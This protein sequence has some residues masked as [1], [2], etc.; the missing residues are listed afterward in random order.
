MIVRD[1]AHHWTWCGF[2][3]TKG[4]KKR[5]GEERVAV[6]VENASAERKR[7]RESDGGP[8]DGSGDN[9]ERIPR[10]ARTRCIA[11][12]GVAAPCAW[13]PVDGPQAST[14]A[15]GRVFENWTS[16]Q[17]EEDLRE[18]AGCPTHNGRW[19][20]RREG[21]EETSQRRKRDRWLTRQNA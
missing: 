20:F 9:V 4:L 11:T 5:H 18:R 6:L 17:E 19:R 1:R 2:V 13:C 14:F 10:E 8:E 16:H 12:D 7:R 21:Y 3:K 15:L